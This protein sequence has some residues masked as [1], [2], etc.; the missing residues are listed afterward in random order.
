M[1]EDVRVAVAEVELA[2]ERLNG[3]FDRYVQELHASEVGGENLDRAIKMKAAMRD[4]G[5][6]YL[7][8]AKHYAGFDETPMMD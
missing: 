7:S 3:A 8:W 2:M 6:I 4:S 1:T 5:A